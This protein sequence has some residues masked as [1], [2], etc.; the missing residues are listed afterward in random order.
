MIKSKL[1]KVEQLV[2]HLSVATSVIS[3][4]FAQKLN[5][6]KLKQGRTSAYCST[7]GL[8]VFYM[9]EIQIKHNYNQWWHMADNQNVAH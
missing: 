7:V 4:F 8:D 5:W 9:N 2:Q 1:K 6:Y 3:Q